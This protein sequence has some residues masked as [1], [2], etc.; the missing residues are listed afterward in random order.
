MAINKLGIVCLITAIIIM[1]IFDLRILLISGF[2]Y[3][4]YK[5]LYKKEQP[6]RLDKIL[7]V[8]LFLLLALTILL[9]VFY[10]T[11]YINIPEVS[12]NLT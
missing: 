12:Q 4:S 5:L 7:I 9:M 10:S 1:F 2:L 3:Y 6:K 8:C 11:N